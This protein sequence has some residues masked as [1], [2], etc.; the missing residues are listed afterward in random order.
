MEVVAEEAGVVEEEAVGVVEALG[1]VEGKMEAMMS[2]VVGGSGRKV[3][4]G[5][6]VDEN[7][8]EDDGEREGQACVLCWSR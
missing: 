5:V 7:E 3:D 8:D 6:G 2:E 1:Q 4:V